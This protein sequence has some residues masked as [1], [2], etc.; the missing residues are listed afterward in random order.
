MLF[1]FFVI[2]AFDPPFLRD[3]GFMM[4]QNKWLAAGAGI[5]LLVLD[6]VAP[7]PSSLVM[8]ANGIL[9]G[10]VAGATLSLAG[11]L[12]AAYCGYWI[13]RKGQNAGQRFTGA[14]AMA[15]ANDFFGRW[16][17]LAV[18]V[19]RPVPIM[20]EAVSIAAGIAGMKPGKMLLA[21]GLG[22]LP[23]ALLYAVAG[24]HSFDLNGGLLS[25]GALIALAGISMAESEC[26]FMVV[27]TPR[28]AH[29]SAFSKNFLSQR[30]PQVSKV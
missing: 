7:V 20:A 27:H 14:A 24:A 23:A 16:G 25:F 9:F 18:M 13:G 26:F 6:V 10:T 22:L 3:A 8:F 15:Q 5:A 30:T 4:R 1:L 2:Q 21:S 17:L 19:S 12:G 28:S 11:G 29:G